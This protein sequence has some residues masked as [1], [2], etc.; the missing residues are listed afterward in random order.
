[1]KVKRCSGPMDKMERFN[2]QV[3]KTDGCWMWKG[4]ISQGRY[5]QFGWNY[6]TLSAHR[7]SYLL[8]VGE[9]PDGMFVCH[10][11]DVP[12][13]VN[14]EHLFL[15]TASDNSRDAAQKGRHYVGEKNARAKITESQALEIRAL[16]LPAPDIAK[17]YGLCP[18]TVYRIK[19][20]TYW[21]HI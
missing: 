7:A 1:M 12:A 18:S 14:P 20:G 16:S 3:D 19:N 17:M 8:H 21:K 4:T 2:M 10:R 9:I 5:G 13:C 11:C 6:R 15:G